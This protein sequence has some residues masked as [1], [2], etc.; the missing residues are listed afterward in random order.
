MGKEVTLSK[1]TWSYRVFKDRNG[2]G[3]REVYYE[4][5]TPT[6]YT[7]LPQCPDEESPEA[8]RN[9]LCRMLHATSKP[10]LT[11]KGGAIVEVNG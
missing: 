1:A 9:V 8:L 4:N 11:D 5:G 6:H 2:Y 10:I 3:L 7:C